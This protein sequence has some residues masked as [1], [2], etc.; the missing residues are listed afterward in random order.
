MQKVLSLPHKSPYSRYHQQQ[1]NT[2]AVDETSFTSGSVNVNA[3]DGGTQAHH[4][5]KFFLKAQSK[6]FFAKRTQ[7]GSTCTK[8]KEI[9]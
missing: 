1:A 3:S 6:A 8:E 9:V 2:C 5:S 7:F 4:L